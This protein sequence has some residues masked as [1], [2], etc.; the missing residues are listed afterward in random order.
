MAKKSQI[1][2]YKDQV[3]TL[4]FGIPKQIKEHE[5]IDKPSKYY[6]LLE[7][8]DVRDRFFTQKVMETQV[9][10]NLKN[11]LEERFCVKLASPGSIFN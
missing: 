5:L 2:N 10:N 8:T 9:V 11:E 1:N 7:S 3:R 4:F 6:R